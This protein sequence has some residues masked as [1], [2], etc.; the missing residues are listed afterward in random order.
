MQLGQPKIEPTIIWLFAPSNFET[1]FE[2]INHGQALSVDTNATQ[3][4][5]LKKIERGAGGSTV[6]L[7]YLS[8]ASLTPLRSIRGCSL[9]DKSMESL[10]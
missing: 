7:S 5:K 2:E 3:Y 6:P 4:P 10:L 9:S 1:W 8:W